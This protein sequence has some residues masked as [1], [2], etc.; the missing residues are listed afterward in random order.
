MPAGSATLAV[1]PLTGVPLDFGD[2]P[3][4]PHPAATSAIAITAAAPPRRNLYLPR[5]MSTPSCGAPSACRWLASSGTSTYPDPGE[6]G[7]AQAATSAW[8]SRRR[9][10]RSGELI[11]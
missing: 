4:E 7:R 10:D 2:E 1:P 11:R 8:A 3:L 5:P 6:Y 9:R